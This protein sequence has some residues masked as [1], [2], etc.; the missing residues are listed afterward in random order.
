M[1][2]SPENQL[3]ES[4]NDIDDRPQCFKLMERWK[5]LKIDTVYA[6]SQ[7]SGCMQFDISNA[8]GRMVFHVWAT[9]LIYEEDLLKEGG[10]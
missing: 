10:K 3:I 8:N 7:K 4:I 1:A 6:G 2:R 9:M 5:K